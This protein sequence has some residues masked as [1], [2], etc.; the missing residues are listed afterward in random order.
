LITRDIK[1]DALIDISAQELAHVRGIVGRQQL[2]SHI[3]GADRVSLCL[4]VILALI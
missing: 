1:E 4:L 2:G 3:F